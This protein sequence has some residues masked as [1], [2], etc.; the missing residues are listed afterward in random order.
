M[1]KYTQI[2]R[3]ELNYSFEYVGA[4]PY[5]GVVLLFVVIHRVYM[6]ASMHIC[7]YVN[8]YIC[9]GGC[10]AV[11]AAC[12]YVDHLAAACAQSRRSRG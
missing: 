7:V 9:V 3:L 6:H 8:V 11:N 4:R 1:M 5:C 10:T 2:C 12:M